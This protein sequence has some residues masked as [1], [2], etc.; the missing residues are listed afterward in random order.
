M[1]FL[2]KRFGKKRLII[3][4]HMDAIVDLLKFDT[5]EIGVENVD[6]YSVFSGATRRWTVPLPTQKIAWVVL[7][8]TP[9]P[10]CLT[11]TWEQPGLQFDSL[12]A[13]HKNLSR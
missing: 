11:S 6:S 1:E 10:S 7:Q 13:W 9:K 2:K 5:M 4:A 12:D 3:Q 8:T